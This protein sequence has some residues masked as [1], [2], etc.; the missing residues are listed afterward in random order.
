[1][2]VF[3]FIFYITLQVVI[4]FPLLHLLMED[5]A[6][7]KERTRYWWCSGCE[8]SRFGGRSI[9]K[10]HVCQ[11]LS[12]IVSNLGVSFLRNFQHFHFKSQVYLAFKSL[13]SASICKPGSPGMRT[14]IWR[15]Q[16]SKMVFQGQS[17]WRSW[18]SSLPWELLARFKEWQ[19]G[20]RLSDAPKEE[21]KDLSKHGMLI[22]RIE[23]TLPICLEHISLFLN[24]CSL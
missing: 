20:A 9:P 16:A 11:L 5:T 23:E 19:Q 15:L 21:G 14:P 13:S 2:S 3:Y 24:I 1:M 12:H 18:D 22:V 4:S 7:L 8:K 17:K 6:F 10:L